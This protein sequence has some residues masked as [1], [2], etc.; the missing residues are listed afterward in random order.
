M[1]H[2]YAKNFGQFSGSVL[3]SYLPDLPFVISTKEGYDRMLGINIPSFYWGGTGSFSSIHIEDSGLDS[4]NLFHFGSVGAVKLW[5]V[6]A[7]GSSDPFRR[8]IQRCVNKLISSDLHRRKDARIYSTWEPKC[9]FP[10]NHKNILVTPALLTRNCINHEVIV[11]RPGDLVYVREGI[12]HA[13]VNI[14]A[15][16]SEA[17]NVGSLSWNMSAHLSHYCCC[18]GS[19]VD[20]SIPINP[21]YAAKITPLISSAVSCTVGSCVSIAPSPSAAAQHSLCHTTPGP[22][23]DAYVCSFCRNRFTSDGA[24][25]HH[26]AL[27]CRQRSVTCFCGRVVKFDSYRKH[28]RRSGHPKFPPF[29]PVFNLG[30]QASENSSLP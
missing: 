28:L 11:Q 20:G 30:K 8:L 14:G 25:L 18:R 5:L 23:P 16:L 29:G 4:C 26:E 2:L 17:V 3:R 6:I 9:R 24:V 10:L 1:P 15:G 7:P 22:V 21:K 27:V 13:V 12:Y 19:H